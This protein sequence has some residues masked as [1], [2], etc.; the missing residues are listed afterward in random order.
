M[1]NFSDCLLQ[2]VDA[3]KLT[4]EK[5]DALLAESEIS[6]VQ[7]ALNSEAFGLAQK[8]REGIIT[9]IRLNDLHEASKAHS[10]GYAKGLMSTMV[11]DVH[12]EAKHFNVDKRAQGITGDY[13]AVIAEMLSRFRT[14]RVG[15]TQDGKGLMDF[16][17]AVFGETIDDVDVKGF[18]DSYKKMQAMM[19]EDFNKAGGNIHI[20]EDYNLP[21]VHD[22]YKV[23]DASVDDWVSFTKPLLDR[24]KMK[25]ADGNL[26]D[27][28]Q[29]D[30]ALRFSYESIK[31]DGLNKV[32]DL[33]LMPKGLGRVLSN[34]H[35]DSRFLHFDGADNWIAY[36]QRFGSND[37][38][39]TI[40]S[41]I[42][43]MA[44]DTALM[45]SYGTNPQATFETML[46]QAEKEG[47]K[48]MQIKALQ[49]QWN[50]ISGKV[51]NKVIPTAATVNQAVRNLITASTLGS[52]VISAMSDTTFSAI[53]SIYR[54]VNA[55][56]VFSQQLKLLNPANES[57][58]IMAVQM[59]LVADA[60]TGAATAANRY[61]ETYGIGYS[62]KISEAVM[63][64]SG[65]VVWTDAGRKAFGMEFGAAI[66]RQFSTPFNSLP[67]RLKKGFDEYGI[68]QADWNAFR[69]TK[70]I[71]KDKAEFADFTQDKS[72]KFINM[73]LTETDF[74]V[75]TPD[76]RTR[77]FQTGGLEAGTAAGE[78]TRHF[79]SLK[80]FPITLIA[81]HGY[82]MVNQNGLKNK[83]AY[84]G[85]MILSTTLMGGMVIQLKDIAAGRE[86]RSIGDTPKEQAKFW[87]AA[88][89]QGGGLG[90]FGDFLFSDVNRFGGGMVQTTIGPVPDLVDKTFKL[91][92]GNIQEA[93]KGDDTNFARELGQYAKRYT[94]K[95][96]QTRLMTDALFDQAILWADPK[97]QRRFNNTMKRRSKEYKQDYWWKKGEVLPEAI[98]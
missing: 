83:A 42:E 1:A 98:R 77:R 68:T 60:W 63:R 81:S 26:L 86:P 32:A 93:A 78:I 69:K 61:G 56:D 44:H 70:K 4:K 45:E 9:T 90:I 27:D 88:M 58:R 94:P 48:P 85:A 20:K 97:A 17:R 29:L 50:V 25:D 49:D 47:A 19:R 84:G 76:S 89:Q 65:L 30:Q 6:G 15:L 3:G 12:G 91:T 41:N 59:G 73:V 79:M 82:R 22:R 71:R 62:A 10:K 13:H 95:T 43:I 52:A 64:G 39:S 31:T 57:D 74:A 92:L 34:K 2:A 55:K 51:N 36:N 87:A 72:G 46:R 40:N 37:I 8:K 66:S 80:S 96:W 16:V 7:E 38:F 18:A 35:S 33:E 28:E 23:K 5:A 54:G 53:T 75:P 14:R 11:R 24:K 67:S 21:Q